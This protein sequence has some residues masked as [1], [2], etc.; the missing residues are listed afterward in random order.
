MKKP[1]IK[2]CEYCG[3]SFE[4]HN[5]HEIK[6]RFC[7]TSCSAKWRCE[8]FGKVRVS[9]T[10][11]QHQR[12]SLQNLW[13]TKEFR[14]N[15]HKRMTENNP[16]YMK[17]VVEKANKTRLK[18][19]SY[20]NNF[21]YGNGKISPQEQKVKDYL[22]KYNFLYNYAIPTKVAKH[23][24]PEKHYGDNYKP[25]FVNLEHFVCIE[26]DGKSHFKK[27]YKETYDDKK[28][29]C[30]NFLGYKVYRFTNEQVDNGE[31]YKEVD[32]ICQ[33]W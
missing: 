32:N 17:G 27:G 22:E 4:I 1:I 14:D 2:I 33:N 20:T 31:F 19:G 15:N 21:K 30:L 16:V 25:D 10:G 5:N 6:K 26:I 7:N 12:E 24:F 28:E 29:E 8:H 9:E 18:N 23:A 13:K 11:R 3:K